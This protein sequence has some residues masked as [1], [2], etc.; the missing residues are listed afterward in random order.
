MG[1]SCWLAQNRAMVDTGGWDG[2][3]RYNGRIMSAP[4]ITIA[5]KIEPSPDGSETY[6]V[7]MD[8]LSQLTPPQR[9]RA[10]H[11][12]TQVID[13]LESAP[14]EPSRRGA[15]FDFG[16]LM[17]AWEKA[18]L[19]RLRQRRSRQRGYPSPFDRGHFD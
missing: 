4:L 9:R 14:L 6:Q 12:L 15:R 5:F 7:M 11:F 18:H 8:G 10:L 17:P 2:R 3:R 13:N 19:E 1:R 16:D